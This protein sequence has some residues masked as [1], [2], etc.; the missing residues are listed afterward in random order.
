VGNATSP[1]EST[2]VAASLIFA[3]ST[4]VGLTFTTFVSIEPKEY[5]KRAEIAR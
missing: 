1:P 4:S 3:K 5:I 2:M